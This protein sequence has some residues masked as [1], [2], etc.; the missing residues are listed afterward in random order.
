MIFT[1][2]NRKL[3]TRI[4]AV[5]SVIAMVGMVGFSLIALFR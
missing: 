5:V 4:W 2:K 1:G 3:V